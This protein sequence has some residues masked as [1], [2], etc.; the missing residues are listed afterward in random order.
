MKG[1]PN[2]QK[3]RVKTHD[4]PAPSEDAHVRDELK[5]EEE[6]RKSLKER[7]PRTFRMRI[8]T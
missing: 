2:R 7:E 1:K 3:E 5:D 8:K 6:S 4:V